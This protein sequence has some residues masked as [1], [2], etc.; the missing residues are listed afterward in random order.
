MEQQV[1]KR[2]TPSKSANTDSKMF[3][4]KCSLKH[5]ADYDDQTTTSFN[6]TEDNEWVLKEDRMIKKIV[7]IR[8][9]GRALGL[10]D[11]EIRAYLDP[12]YT[13]RLLITYIPKFHIYMAHCKAMWRRNLFWTEI[14]SKL[15]PSPW[16]WN[17]FNLP[18]ILMILLMINIIAI[19]IWLFQEEN[20]CLLGARFVTAEL[21]RP[22]FPCNLCENL[23]AVPEVQNISRQE[24]VRSF[25]Y[26]SIPLLVKGAARHWAALD[27]FS[28]EYFRSLYLNHSSRACQFFEYN[29]EFRNL[30][31]ALNMSPDRAAFKKDER[32]WYFGWSNC[33]PTINEKLMSQYERPYFLPHDRTI[34]TSFRPDWIFM[35]GPGVAAESHI[36]QVNLPS[37]QAQVSGIKTWTLIPSPECSTLF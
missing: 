3:L 24:F 6:D 19:I 21:F 31:E 2:R 29:T 23:T 34:N 12:S 25:G 28:F 1:T 13:P 11:E 9:H 18:V 35:G 20:E 4:S 33:D 5:S 17:M 10:T 15:F 36:D 22:L 37:W 26:S 14:G 8:L 16:K 27:N 32:P 30:G 7:A